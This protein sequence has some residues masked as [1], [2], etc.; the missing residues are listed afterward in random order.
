MTRIITL[1]IALCLVAACR[2]EGEIGLRA[3]AGP[4]YAPTAAEAPEAPAD[5]ED[6]T[7]HSKELFIF[8]GEDPEAVEGENTSLTEEDAMP[9]TDEAR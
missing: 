1:G 5:E 3:G 9:G 2:T 4:D 8:D 7:G 6:G